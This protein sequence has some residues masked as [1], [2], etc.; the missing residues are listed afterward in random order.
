M[1]NRVKEKI[2]MTDYKK[3]AQCFDKALSAAISASVESEIQIGEKDFEAEKNLCN[4][5]GE[6][7]F[8]ADVEKKLSADEIFESEN[9]A[10]DLPIFETAKEK[11]NWWH[12]FGSH[13]P[14]QILLQEYELGWGS[15]YKDNAYGKFK[16]GYNTEEH[17]ASFAI[18]ET[19]YYKIQFTKYDGEPIDR[20]AAKK[21]L[22]KIN[23]M[24]SERN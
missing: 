19:H 23:A 10:D 8:S 6:E 15:V 3:L 24:R 22:K 7:N 13:C 11:I 12:A 1:C 9:V 14:L 20:Q 2:F 5:E 18:D 4:R 17:F 16:I 21:V